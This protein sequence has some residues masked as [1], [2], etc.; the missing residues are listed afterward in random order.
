MPA[1]NEIEPSLN[2]GNAAQ[3]LK[4]APKTLRLAAEAGEMKS[5][6]SSIGSSWIFARVA[7]TTS[8]AQSITKRARQ[9][10]KYPAGSRPNQQNLFSSIT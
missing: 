5:L 9:N 6:S 8:A 7:L 4:I 10:P 1:E 3:I 2:L